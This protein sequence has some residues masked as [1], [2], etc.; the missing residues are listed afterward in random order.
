MDL[1]DAPTNNSVERTA[2]SEERFTCFTG[3]RLGGR[4]KDRPARS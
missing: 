1:T 3:W 2:G 4:M